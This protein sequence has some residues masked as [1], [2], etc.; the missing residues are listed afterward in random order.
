[1][2]KP[3][4][5]TLPADPLARV[6]TLFAQIYSHAKETIGEQFVFGAK[7]A[8][9]MVGLPFPSIAL[10]YLLQTTC[11][12]LSRLT[13]LVGKPASAKTVLG[14]EISRWHHNWGG[15]SLY[16]DCE[17]KNASHIR[18]GLFQHD[19]HLI[20]R[21]ATK[22]CYTLEQAQEAVFKTMASVIQVAA[23]HNRPNSIPCAFMI[24]SL[25][26]NAPKAEFESMEKN[27][28][29]AERGYAL[30]AQLIARWMR[31]VQNLIET[32][33]FSILVTNH[34]RESTDRMGN[35]V[36][37]TPGGTSVPYFETLELE[38]RR[39]RPLESQDAT[40]LSI[41]IK[42]FKNCVGPAGRSIVADVLWWYED[43]VDPQTGEL[44]LDEFGVPR[45]QQ[46]F[47]W[48]WDTATVNMLKALQTEKA[49]LAK[50]IANDVVDL[51]FVGKADRGKNARVWSDALGIPED[52]PQL[53]R[54]AGRLIQN[55]PSMLSKLR[56]HLDIL[57]MT[58]F[59]QDQNYREAL[60]EAQDRAKE[61]V[62][63]E[64]PEATQVSIDD[65]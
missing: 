47:T 65:E 50:T 59:S 28:G 58:Q 15:G 9:V 44:V 52:D 46:F 24:D 34:L 29:A 54:E 55:N 51:N 13:T 56:Y 14:F 42:V 11:W 49:T 30:S 38:L 23:E 1:M 40:G 33:P 43:A 32:N 18:S 22:E 26:G 31:G 61:R 37:V 7:S 19:Q 10:E 17:H 8:E 62:E 2:A 21:A 3:K 27:D 53:Y 25:M 20:S 48:D 16:A 4:K 45:K 41:A 6:D 5:S 63:A 39:V 36:R 12:P 57:E 64:A 60:R 35:H